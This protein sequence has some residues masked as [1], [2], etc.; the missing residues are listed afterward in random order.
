MG[1]AQRKRN[2]T[3][4]RQRKRKPVKKIQNLN[5]LTEE[6]RKVWNPKKSVKQNYETI[7]IASEITISAAFDEPIEEYQEKESS[8]EETVIPPAPSEGKLI[9]SRNIQRN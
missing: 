3:K 2:R 1:I 9:D 5:G 6:I 4:V 8:E 7:G